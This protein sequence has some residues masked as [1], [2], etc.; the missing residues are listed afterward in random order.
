MPSVVEVVDSVH[1]NG[2]S[3]E[4]NT[5]ANKMEKRVAD[6]LVHWNPANNVR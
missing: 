6:I 3:V 2:Q 1:S 5:S 4:E